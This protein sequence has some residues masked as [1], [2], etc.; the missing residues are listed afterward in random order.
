MAIVRNA[1]ESDLPYLYEICL[2]TGDSGKDATDLFHDPYLLGQYYAAPYLFHDRGL[3]FVLEAEY[4]PQGYIIAA[5]DTTE[6][7]CWMERLWLPPLR[8][9]YPKP[10][11]KEIVK[12]KNEEA[13]LNHLHTVAILP[14][15]QLTPWIVDH[16]AHLHID[17]LPAMQGQGFGRELMKALFA[18][19]GRRGIPGVHLGVGAGN[20]G[21]VAFYHK[22]GFTVLQEAPWGFTLGQLI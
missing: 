21:A 16:P 19:L 5:A 20:Q 6:F 14:D 2:K 8:L 9:R 11:P 17:L 15:P 12:S 7:R 10:F 4:R 1:V 18:E 22:M 3:C 13:I